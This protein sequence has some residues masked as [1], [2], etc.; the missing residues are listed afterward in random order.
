MK[1]LKLAECGC[2]VG[3]IF[4]CYCS[5]VKA[6]QTKVKK[7]L[8]SCK[9][10]IKTKKKSMYGNVEE[11]EENF[12]NCRSNSYMNLSS[13]GGVK[14]LKSM[15][16]LSTK[17]IL[18]DDDQDDDDEEVENTPPAEVKTSKSKRNSKVREGSV[19]SQQ[20]DSDLSDSSSYSSSWDSKRR[21]SNLSTD[22]RFEIILPN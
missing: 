1:D 16:H 15:L 17:K 18:D 12:D 5:E 21:D 19:K 3:D 10:F 2:E 7:V 22:R 9:S 6:N 20:K 4:K 14:G 8:K 11:R 13:N